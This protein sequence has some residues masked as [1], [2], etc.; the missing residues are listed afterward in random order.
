MGSGDGRLILNPFIWKHTF[1]IHLTD[2]SIYCAL[3][4]MCCML[5]IEP[6]LSYFVLQWPTM[7]L[8]TNCPPIH[9]TSLNDFIVVLLRLLF[10]LSWPCN[11]LPQI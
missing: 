9:Y 10:V 5:R 8:L 1:V 6:K 4:I 3:G 7:W 2:F 11:K